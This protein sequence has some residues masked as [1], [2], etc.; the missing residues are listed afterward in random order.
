MC[1][2]GLA[3]ILVVV[4]LR[5]ARSRRAAGSAAAA[6]GKPASA[7][8]QGRG[9]RKKSSKVRSSV[10]VAPAPAGGALPRQRPQEP[11]QVGWGEEGF[12]SSRAQRSGFLQKSS[13][14]PRAASKA[15]SANAA[16]STAVVPAS[17]P[18]RKHPG[19]GSG[20]GGRSSPL[21]P[22]P[23]ILPSSGA[24]RPQRPTRGS[25]STESPKLALVPKSPEVSIASR[26]TCFASFRL[27]PPIP[28]VAS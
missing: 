15:F 13:G 3:V 7:E 12:L 2:T 11:L 6:R 28:A 22:P 1:V 16:A 25:Q 14:S 26:R 9:S 18:S 24:G 21:S 27:F 4:A 5:R 20:A 17:P 19:P 8:S 10:T 23:S